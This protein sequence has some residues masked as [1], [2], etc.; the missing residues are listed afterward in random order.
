MSDTEKAWYSL[1]SIIFRKVIDSIKTRFYEVLRNQ[2][3][4]INI[5]HDKKVL[6]DLVLFSTVRIFLRYYI[7]SDFYELLSMLCSYTHVS[8]LMFII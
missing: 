8:F 2:E 1:R 7:V 3:N 6:T 4:T 5:L